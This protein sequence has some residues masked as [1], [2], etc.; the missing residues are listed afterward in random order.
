MLTELSIDGYLLSLTISFLEP[1]NLLFVFQFTST[2]INLH[3]YKQ[4]KPSYRNHL[5]EQ[6][7]ESQSQ[8]PLPQEAN[9]GTT[10][11]R[12]CFNGLNV[13]SGVGILS[14][15][16]AVSQGGWL[17]LILLFFIAILC[18]Y[19]GLLLQRCMNE[20]LQVKTYPDIG[21]LAFGCKGRAVVSILM[22]LELY[23]VAVEFLILEGDNLEKLF[24]NMGFKFAGF[25]IEGKQG[26]IL[27]TALIILPTT[28]L[29]SLGI[30][31]YVS[32]GG[33]LASVFLVCCI[34]WAGAVDGVGFHGRDQLLLN[35][36]G[37]PTAMSLFAFCYCGHAVFPTLCNS[38][39]D[40]SQFSKVLLVCFV[41]STITYGSMAILG[42]LMYGAYSKSQVT[43]N[44]PITKINTK[45][46]IYATLINPLTKYAFVI[47]PIANAVEDTYPFC[48][49]SLSI[50]CRTVIVISTVV[51]AL[52]IPFFG[53]VMAFIGGFLSVTLSML[54][55]CLCYLKINKTARRFG[56]ELLIIMG[57]IV[58]GSFVGIVGTYTSVKQIVKHL[59]KS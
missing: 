18:W 42:Y 46:A 57:I 13:L 47:T 34:L 19:T 52:T 11:F 59:L 48:K 24:P 17:S 12:T 37:L 15:P 36:E 53:Y 8:L 4:Q 32:V 7:M 43:L 20:H 38:M 22:Y 23:L 26:F 58:I 29:R 41:T 27:L 1:S 14:M 51:V 56:L 10:F 3:L 54:L 55:P 45:I 50:L 40:R 44:L 6:S 9:K 2:H 31:A 21:E 28:W 16:Y 5:P 39:K 33:V 25:R 49:R 35:W 30:L